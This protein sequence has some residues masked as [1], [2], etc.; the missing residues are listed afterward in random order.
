MVR[1]D[2]TLPFFFPYLAWMMEFPHT[3]ILQLGSYGVPFCHR[4]LTG[5]LN[6]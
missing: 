2:Y 3:T 5:L 4:R 6:A 1:I